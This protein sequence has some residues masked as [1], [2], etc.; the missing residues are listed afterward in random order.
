VVAGCPGLQSLLY[1]WVNP[2]FG[3]NWIQVIYTNA[4]PP[5]SDTRSVIVAPP[6]Q[7]SGLSGN[8]RIIMWNGIPGVNYLV[9]ATTNLL[10][11]FQ[12]IS[13]LIPGVGGSTEFF[14]PD[15]APQKFYEIV[16]L[17]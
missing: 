15:P 2:A 5:L 11:P 8:D 1:N 13:G 7:V 6:L 12:V 17:P 4:T 3:T 16:M 14:D 10:Q 9:L